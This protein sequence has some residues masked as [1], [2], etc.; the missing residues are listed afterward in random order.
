MST[1]INELKAKIEKMEK[2]LAGGNIPESAKLGVENSLKVAKGQLAELEATQKPSPAK[3]A[4]KLLKRDFYAHMNEQYPDVTFNGLDILSQEKYEE[5]YAAFLKLA[6]TVADNDAQAKEYLEAWINVHIPK[7]EQKVEPKPKPEPK[8]KKKKAEPAPKPKKEELKPAYSWKKKIATA[9]LSPIIIG[10]QHYAIKVEKETLV[11]LKGSGS[12]S[13][14]VNAMP[15]EYLII[16]ANGY[17]VFVMEPKSYKEKCKVQTL[18]DQKAKLAE[19]EKAISGLKIANDKIAALEK[20][21]EALK[22][23]KPEPT[24]KLKKEES[25]PEPKAKKKKAEPTPKPKKKP[26]CTLKEAEMGRRLAK[27][28]KFFTDH[29]EKWH[30]DKVSW[31]ITK[32][33]RTKGEKQEIIIEVADYKGFMTGLK[34]LIGGRRSYKRLC[35][36]S[37]NLTTVEKPERGKYVLV[38]SESEMKRIYTTKGDKKYYFCL[39]TYRELLKCSFEGKCTAAQSKKWKE[40]Y[41]SCGDLQQKLEKNPEVLRNFHAE[42]KKRRKPTE[43]YAEAMTRVAEE[44]KIKSV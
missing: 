44:I 3:T 19:A 40:L 14:Q 8:A 20:T 1:A 42:V 33:Y 17:L 22:A 37:L 25:K 27:A 24:P 5:S 9:N 38:V 23:Q 29:A 11:E 12:D 35:V 31:K 26:A 10:C 21:I 39:K 18:E 15:G 41:N 30:N 36:D 7:G 6:K 32:I 34:T 13:V 4:Q 2:G 28:V 43:T 16:D